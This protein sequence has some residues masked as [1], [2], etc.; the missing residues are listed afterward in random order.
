MGEGADGSE[1]VDSE[2]IMSEVEQEAQM[3]EALER[4]LFEMKNTVAELEKRLNSVEDQDN[5]WKTRYETQIELNRQLERQIGLFQ[6]K[7]QHVC[8]NPAD[9]LAS[10]RSFDQMHLDSL[11]QFLKQLEEDKK[12]LQNQLK[13]YTLRL[14]QEGKAYHKV[15]DEC[16]AYLAVISQ[17]YYYLHQ[18]Q[19]AHIGCF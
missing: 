12:N 18:V 11:N 13:E 10:V 7:M 6:H 17:A 16:R 14:E 9:R 4:S 5:E 19:H 1:L 15:N 2:R 8:D 3:K